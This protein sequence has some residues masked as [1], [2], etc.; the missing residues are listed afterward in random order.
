MAHNRQRLI[1]GIDL[2]S[3]Y[4]RIAVGEVRD[5][6]LDIIGVAETPSKGISKGEVTNIEDAISSISACLEQVEKVIGLPVQDVFVGVSGTHMIFQESRGVVSIARAD[7]AI[8]RDDVERVLEA[9]QAVVSLANYE[10]LHILPRSFSVDN[11]PGVI[12]PVGMVGTRLEVNAQII[13]GLTNQIRSLTKCF[14]RVGVKVS[15]LVVNPLATA[16]AILSERQKE[17]GVLLINIGNTTTNIAVF[18]DG[19]ILTIKIMPFGSRYITTDLAIGLRV[20]IDLAEMIKINHGTVLPISMIKNKKIEF[21]DLD[22]REKGSASMKEVSKIIKGRCEKT[23]KLID[24]E[25]AFIGRRNKLPAGIVL[26]GAGSKLEGLV[27]V[28][29]N[30]FKLPASL[31]SLRGFVGNNKALDIGFATAVGLIVWGAERR[32]RSNQKGNKELYRF[33]AK[34]KGLKSLLKNLFLY[35]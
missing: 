5:G 35:H 7:R 31:G 8:K 12:D 3:N 28:A 11:Q 17:L 29:K 15:E 21:A 19:N 23:F 25:L 34:L 22:K 1:S 4:I 26:A 13:L 9:A 6:V 24:E 27:N 2:G 14:D 30:V 18:E 33:S 32:G 20:P 16:R 10:V